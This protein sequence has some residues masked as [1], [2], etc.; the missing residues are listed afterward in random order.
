MFFASNIVKIESNRAKEPSQVQ[1]KLRVRARQA[2]ST[3]VKQ[4][5]ANLENQPKHAS[6]PTNQLNNQ[7]TNQLSKQASKPTSLEKQFNL[8]EASFAT[9]RAKHNL[10]KSSQ[11][12]PSKRTKQPS[13]D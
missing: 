10:S 12:K 5:R 4:C 9:K 2:P 8:S 7:V 3:K 1:L 13:Q 6:A 11:A